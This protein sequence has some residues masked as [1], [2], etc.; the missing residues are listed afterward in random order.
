VRQTIL[1]SNAIDL[2][3]ESIFASHSGLSLKWPYGIIIYKMKIFKKSIG[4]MEEQ[5]LTIE[6][7]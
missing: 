5:H 3:R 7:L 4:A 2:T 6:K 1:Q